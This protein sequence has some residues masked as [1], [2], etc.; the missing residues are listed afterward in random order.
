MM[1]FP[2]RKIPT[3]Y[4]SLTKVWYYK[5][6]ISVKSILSLN[7]ICYMFKSIPIMLIHHLVVR[8]LTQNTKTK[9]D[10]HFDFL[11][12][13]WNAQIFSL[14]PSAVGSSSTHCKI[15]QTKKCYREQDLVFGSL[16]SC[17]NFL[18]NID[19]FNLPF[20]AVFTG[21]CV[22]VCVY[23][24]LMCCWEITFRSLRKSQHS[25]FQSLV[26]IN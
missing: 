26:H 11:E 18:K 25:K 22:C 2:N 1:I 4:P 20:K 5:L 8:I 17:C 12:L 16:T 23:F 9:S 24:W 6:F 3:S 7:K 10:V 15:F 14:L 21:K 13:S 19:Y